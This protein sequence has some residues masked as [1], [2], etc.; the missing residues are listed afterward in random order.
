MN[1][2]FSNDAMKVLVKLDSNTAG[3]II[4]GII[5]LPGKGD[6]KPLSGSS[7]VY[8][9]RIGDYRVLFKAYDENNILIET[10][11][12]RGNAYKGV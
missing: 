1:F 9:L 12:P 5:K 2:D 3:R 10:I 11:S 6:I 4:K 7:G 8:R